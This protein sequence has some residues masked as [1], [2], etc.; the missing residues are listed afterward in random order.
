MI[1]Q[2]KST[3][4][5]CAPLFGLYE[6]AVMAVKTQ[7]TN[8]FMVKNKKWK[9]LEDWSQYIMA[10]PMQA[11]WQSQL[12]SFW[13]RGLPGLERQQQ[14]LTSKTQFKK[15]MYHMYFFLPGLYKWCILFFFVSSIEKHL[16]LA[17]L[18][19]HWSPPYIWKKES[20]DVSNSSSHVLYFS[21]IV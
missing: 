14:T 10:S 1:N 13:C 3:L 5:L 6:K 12:Q 21:L 19:Q 2:N 8:L 7:K 11:D 15:I 4:C 20:L 18:L 9:Y 17:L 16:A